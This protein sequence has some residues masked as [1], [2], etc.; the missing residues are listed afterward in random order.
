NW[1]TLT[2]SV[3]M[4]KIKQ[5]AADLSDLESKFSQLSWTQYTTG[6]DFG[7]EEAHLKITAHFKDKENY[8]IICDAMES[9]LSPEDRR[10]VEIL[11]REFKRYHY[12]ERANKLNEEII[13]LEIK[14]TNVLNKHRVVFD[15]K[16]VDKPTL[17]KIISENPDQNTRKR[18]FLA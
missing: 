13:A 5:I 2:M 8:R 7:V 9:D 6:L 17:G 11:Y 16:E 14:L 1:R 4:E 15:G 10:S 12:S 3:V 18:A